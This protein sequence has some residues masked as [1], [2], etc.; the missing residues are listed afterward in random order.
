MNKRA[1]KTKQQLILLPS[2]HGQFLDCTA[3][4]HYVHHALYNLQN[5]SC[6]CRRRRNG[7]LLPLFII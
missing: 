3:L 5:C 6:Q 4:L 1:K 2:F 7:L